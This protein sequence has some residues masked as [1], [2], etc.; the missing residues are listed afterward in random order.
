MINILVI[1]FMSNVN[2]L[3]MDKCFWI[4]SNFYNWL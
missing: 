3:E 4:R 1:I 2:K